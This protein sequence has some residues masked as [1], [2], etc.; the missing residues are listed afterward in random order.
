MRVIAGKLGGRVFDSPGSHRTHPMSD[1]VKGA[2]FNVLGG[3]DGM[4]VLDAFAGSG[5]LGF[6]AISRGA[7]H[8]VAIESDRQAQKVIEDNITSLG[9]SRQVK[10]I[11][12][13]AN[14][15][16]GTNQGVSF[17]IVLCDPPYDD[18]QPNLLFRLAERIAIGGIVVLSLPPKADVTLQPEDFELEVEKDYGDARLVFYRRIR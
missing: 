13:T 5:A 12:A 18:L 16:L 1:K 14:A 7:E 10:L 9:V 4:K 3:L 11:K 17:D 8:V 15:W 2:L 6:E